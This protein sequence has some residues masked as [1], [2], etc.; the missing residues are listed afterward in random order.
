MFLL[1][2]LGRSTLLWSDQQLQVICEQHR[3]PARHKWPSD[4][5]LHSVGMPY[6][7]MQIYVHEAYWSLIYDVYQH[8][9]G[10]DD[11]VPFRL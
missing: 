2:I 9:G 10:A 4:V 8:L 6:T 3:Q 11:E 1:L 7:V 5:V